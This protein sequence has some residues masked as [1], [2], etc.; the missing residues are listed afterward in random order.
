LTYPFRRRGRGCTNL[1]RPGS[2]HGR[3]RT[4]DS[5]RNGRRNERVSK[6]NCSRKAARKASPPTPA[7]TPA[8]QQCI[9]AEKR[10]ELSPKKANCERGGDAIPS[11]DRS[12][13]VGEG[14]FLGSAFS[15]EGSFS[16]SS[17]GAAAGGRLAR[18]RARGGRRGARC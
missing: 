12:Q 5:N 11:S 8:K 15:A 17:G 10:Q 13:R 1:V 14:R 7:G 4:F 6:A 16:R 9:V 3:R 2:N 18:R